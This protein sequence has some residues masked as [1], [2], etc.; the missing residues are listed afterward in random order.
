VRAGS[1]STGPE[2]G[3]DRGVVGGLILRE[4]CFQLV[5]RQCRQIGKV[6][7]EVLQALHLLA[8][9]RLHGDPLA[10]TDRVGRR[11][12]PH[13]DYHKSRR[14]GGVE[15]GHQ[16]LG[17]QHPRRLVYMQPGLNADARYGAGSAPDVTTDLPR[18]PRIVA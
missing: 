5:A 4:V 9:L 7:V 17:H 8:S 13:P 3:P 16:V 11:H 14:L 15:Q 10:R 1:A 6:A 2:G 18:G 12:L